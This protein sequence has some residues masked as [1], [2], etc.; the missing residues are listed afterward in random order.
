MARHSLIAAA[1]L[2]LVIVLGTAASGG[3][4]VD[5]VKVQAKAG[6]AAAGDKQLVVVTLD[7]DKGWH[8]YANPV[9][10]EDLASAETTVQIK[11]AGKALAAKVKY[12][13]GTSH[14]EKGIGTF[15]I[16]EHQVNIEAEFPRS[17]NAVEVSVKFQACDATRC[18]PSKT[19]TVS[20]K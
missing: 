9:A 8:V 5:P 12:P 18:L 15:K 16:Y 11:A 1:G 13:E 2:A 14:T 20:V 3:G 6:K 7:I 19:V 4:K 17:D 10:N